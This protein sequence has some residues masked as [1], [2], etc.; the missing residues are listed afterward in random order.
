MIWLHK[1][2][3]ISLF[4][5]AG[6]VAVSAWEVVRRVQIAGIVVQGESAPDT[7]LSSNRRVLL[8]LLVQHKV[9]TLTGVR[10][11]M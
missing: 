11:G 6:S 3:F 8:K 5:T 1:D 9:L 2:T 10:S 7:C 4:P